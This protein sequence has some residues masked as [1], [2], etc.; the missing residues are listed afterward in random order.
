MVPEAYYHKR[1]YARPWAD[2]MSRYLRPD[3]IHKRKTTPEKKT[4]PPPFKTG[5]KKELF[6][7]VPTTPPRRTTR[8]RDPNP[9]AQKQ[10]KGESVFARL[11]DPSRSVHTQPSSDELLNNIFAVLT[12]GFPNAFDSAETNRYN[13]AIPREGLVLDLDPPQH[14][15]KPKIQVKK[16]RSASRGIFH[17]ARPPLLARRRPH[18]DRHPPR[19]ALLGLARLP[20]VRPRAQRRPLRSGPNTVL[21]EGFHKGPLRQLRG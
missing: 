21:E 10:Q 2:D 1:P 4:A 11:A 13:C 7:D 14:G 3:Q 19:K 18:E 12:L 6:G 5:G 8:R 20:L 16:H 9:K 15:Y 17:R